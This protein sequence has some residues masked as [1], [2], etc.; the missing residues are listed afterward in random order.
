MSPTPEVEPID[1]RCGGHHLLDEPEHAVLLRL[2]KLVERLFQVPIAYIALLGPEREVVTRIGSGQDYWESLKTYPLEPV[3][4]KP[5]VWPDPSGATVAGFHCG[6][7]R[8]AAAAALRSSDG[9]ELGLLVIADVQERPEYSQRDQETLEELASVLAGKMELRALACEAREAELSLRE[10]ESR[11]RSIAN[12]A[13]VMLIYSG[14]DGGSSFVNQTWLEFTGRSFAQELEEGY[15]DS[16]HP[17]YRGRVVDTYWEAFQARRPM[18]MEFPMRRH[19]GEYRWMEARGMPRF[20]DD[21][22]YAGY[23]G[24]FIDMTE[25]R[26]ANLDLRKQIL[27]TAA[28]AQAAGACYLILDGEGR[29]EY[30]SPLCQRAGGAEEMR[31]CFLWE[32]CDAAAQG[33]AA[34]EDAIRRAASSRAT[35]QVTVPYG[36]AGEHAVM[37]LRWRFTPIFSEGG[38]LIAV[39]AAALEGSVDRKVKSPCAHHLCVL[40]PPAI[41]S[42]GAGCDIGV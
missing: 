18:T 12:S 17:D 29:I 38:E 27:C 22:K 30:V 40:P 7:L 16:F 36:G 9:L 33:R 11:F 2:T 23:I 28:V 13:P 20:L 5:R 1:S 21:G 37:E 24:C 10:A 19:D 14:V 6:D 31:G 4:A 41:E 39:G 35:V 32:A 25:R 3:L 15:A 26:T 42:G 8:F 34:V